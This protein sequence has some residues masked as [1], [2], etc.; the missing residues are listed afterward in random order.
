[1]SEESAPIRRGMFSNSILMIRPYKISGVWVFDEPRLEIVREPFVGET[2]VLI[3]RL[4]ADAGVRD[5]EKGFTMM[6]SSQPFP[7]YQIELTWVRDEFQG[8]WYR[9]DKYII[10]GWLCAVMYV[11][12]SEA[13]KKIFVKAQ[14]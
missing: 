12:F 1:M 7:G 4:C 2:N 11:Y 8:N 6:F 3:D 13:P 9:C 5:A 14:S 10:E